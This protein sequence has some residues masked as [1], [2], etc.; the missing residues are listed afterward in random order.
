MSNRITAA[1]IF[2]VFALTAI[3]VA[4]GGYTNGFESIQSRYITINGEAVKSEANILIPSSSTAKI[5]L[6]NAGFSKKTDWDYS[7]LIFA[8]ASDTTT[9][10]ADGESF[11]L[12]D[13][14]ELTEFFTIE[15]MAS[16]FTLSGVESLDEILSRK[17]NGATIEL[18]EPVRF[19]FVLSVVDNTDM[20]ALSFYVG[21]APASVTGIIIDPPEI[22]FGGTTAVGPSLNG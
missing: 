11:K 10:T 19:P 3:L 14:G 20:K 12:S 21:L 9:Y 18:S 5:T 15:K 13:V 1:L 22:I 17:H 2:L 8:N 4:V 7:V 6:K 16:S